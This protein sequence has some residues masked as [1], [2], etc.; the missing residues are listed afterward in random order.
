MTR[1][2]LLSA[3]AGVSAVVVGAAVGSGPTVAAAQ[4]HG[5][6]ALL[7]NCIDY[8]LIQHVNRYMSLRG[9]TGKYDQVVLAG[10]S[11]AAVY[12]GLPDW[13]QTFWDQLQV[14]SDLHNIARVIVLDHRDCGAFKTYLGRDYGQEPDAETQVHAVYL[15]TLRQQINARHP[16]LEVEL[17]L[18]SLD[19]SVASFT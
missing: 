9:M 4:T 16:E 18:M 14:S 1:R 11:L 13:N 19:G 5:V 15:D 6:E 3:A 17:M 10:A 7:L 2:R 12:P 8:R